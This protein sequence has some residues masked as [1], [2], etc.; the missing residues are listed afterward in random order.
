MSFHRSFRDEAIPPLTSAG[1]LLNRNGRRFLL[2]ATEFEDYR[3]AD[4]FDSKLRLMADFGEL[5]QAG[6]NTLLMGVRSADST[7]DLCALAGLYAIVE[8]QA[9][10]AAILDRRGL[11]R[12]L[13]RFETSARDLAGRPALSGFLINCPLDPPT[14]RF[15]GP[16]RIRN[17]IGALIDVIRAT[18]CGNSFV[19]VRTRLPEPILAPFDED[20]TYVTTAGLD[21][22]AIRKAIDS[23]R[24]GSG[25]RP[26]HNRPI[27][28]E[29]C[30]MHGGMHAEDPDLIASLTA[31]GVAGFVHRASLIEQDPRGVQVSA[32]ALSHA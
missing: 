30:G 1:N 4:N 12:V 10:P 14:I 31:D 2:R 29:L 16:A 9:D 23:A 18:S 15:H 24:G 19:A 13:S 6:I 5:K 22:S 21:V 26:S 28:V 25:K 17:V 27:I 7:L 32:S 11:R 8:I 3:R 20:L